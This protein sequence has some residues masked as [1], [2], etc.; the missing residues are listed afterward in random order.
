MTLAHKL[1]VLKRL[2]DLARE[3]GAADPHKMAHQIGMLIDGAIVVSMISRDPGVA[4][5]AA[6]TLEGIFTAM[7][8][9]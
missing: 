7:V 4:H 8:V 1:A 2:E 3:A 9:N 6:E 5:L